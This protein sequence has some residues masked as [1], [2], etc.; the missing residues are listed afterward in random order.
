MKHERN[1]VAAA[2]AA[3]LILPTGAHAVEFAVS[4]HVN[5]AIVSVD[6]A[7]DAKGNDIDSGLQHKDGAT[8][9]SRFRFTG[10]EELESGMG[11]G[12]NLEMGV[13]ESGGA[14]TSLRHKYVYL[15]T[16]GGKITI[17]HTS[18]AADNAAHARLGGLSWLGGV[19]NYCAYYDKR[20]DGVDETGA[21][22]ADDTHKKDG[23][24]DTAAGC[25]TH[26]GDRRPILRYDTPSF[27]PASISIATGNDDYW[28]TQLKFAGS[29][30]DAG[31]DLRFGYIG[32]Y[33]DP[34]S[35]AAVD[36]VAPGHWTFTTGA[37]LI[38][39]VAPSRGVLSLVSGTSKISDLRKVPGY[40]DVEIQTW[41]AGTSAEDTP[42]EGTRGVTG[43][44]AD[45]ATLADG[46]S[47]AVRTP[48]KA[49]KAARVRET[50]KGDMSIASA[51][52]AFGQGT[53]VAVAWGKSG[54]DDPRTGDS[55]H[56]YFEVDHKYDGNSSVGVSWRR[57]EVGK[58][59]LKRKGSSWG[60]GWGH[61]IGSGAAVYAGYQQI[62]ED[63]V[64]E[65]VGV[66]NVGMRVTFN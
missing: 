32:E 23:K 41:V 6:D 12:V 46:D 26:D 43:V 45:G 28:D 48:G 2:V 24:V 17:G 39:T 19:T 51:A 21:F 9:G 59:A 65:N 49:A 18:T 29:F 14:G 16:V 13:N 4:G 31:Y 57:G 22:N 63:K 8:S 20:P 38:D 53:S 30:G 61:D 60:V 7:K 25:T 58:G 35:I 10:S 11:V 34:T 55:Q 42:P 27:G 40:K 33:D 15:D 52:V 3:A 66:F 37:A 64:K 5:R 54:L 62:K 1:A 36:A 47:L 50:K 44:V 56:T